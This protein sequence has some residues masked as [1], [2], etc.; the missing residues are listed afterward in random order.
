VLIPDCSETPLAVQLDVPLA[1]PEAL[2]VVLLHSTRVTRTLSVDVPFKVSV[3][4]AVVLLFVGL[5][6]TT[7]G[8]DVSGP[9]PPGLGDGDGVLV[10]VLTGAPGALLPALPPPPQA[11]SHKPASNVRVR[12]IRFRPAGVR[13]GRERNLDMVLIFIPH[14]SVIFL[15]ALNIRFFPTLFVCTNLNATPSA[16]TSRCTNIT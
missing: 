5:E 2:V 4:E 8:A 3:A 16:G 11:V 13:A 9:D 14:S 15:A 6:I 1:L 10:L 12:G 7:T